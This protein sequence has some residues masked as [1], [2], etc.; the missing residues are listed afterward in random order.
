MSLR[1]LAEEIG[2]KVEVRPIPVE[3][4][5]EFDEVGACGTAAVIS[6]ICAI[7]DRDTHTIYTYCKD[8]TSDLFQPVYIKC[9][10]EFS[11]AKYPISTA[12][13]RLFHDESNMLIEKCLSFGRGTFFSNFQNILFY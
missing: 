13:L 5:T 3:E 7:E 10:K 1:T 9:F 4:L 8:G 6:P 12:G 11:S 2:L